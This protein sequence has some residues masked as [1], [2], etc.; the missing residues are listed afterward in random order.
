M[1]DEL[2]TDIISYVKSQYIM[3]KRRLAFAREHTVIT[4]V[5]QPAMKYAIGH[6]C[7]AT[8]VVNVIAY[9]A[10]HQPSQIRPSD[11]RHAIDAL[12]LHTGITAHL[13]H[14]EK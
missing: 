4:A 7:Q 1:D 9:R 6:I 13:F 8:S 3:I 11:F 14:S 2:T 12:R 10:Q 5:M